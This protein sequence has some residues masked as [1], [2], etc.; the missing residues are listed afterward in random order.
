M[1]GKQNCCCCICSPSRP[2]ARALRRHKSVL[3]SN[4]SLAWGGTSKAAQLLPW[5]TASSA[6]YRV[7]RCFICKGDGQLVHSLAYGS[8]TFTIRNS[9][10]WGLTICSMQTGITARSR[11]SLLVNGLVTQI[12]KSE[13]RT[14]HVP[15]TLLMNGPSLRLLG[16]ETSPTPLLHQLLWKCR[17]TL[18]RLTST[19]YLSKTCSI[20]KFVAVTHDESQVPPYRPA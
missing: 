2:V 15:H 10:A 5:R 9:P 13:R 18:Y 4:P 12:K 16:K 3:N 8:E 6:S 17:P 1:E 14:Q 7:W 11:N 19:A 20:I